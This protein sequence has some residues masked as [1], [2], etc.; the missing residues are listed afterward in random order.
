MK[1]QYD[2]GEFNV[3][4]KTDGLVSLVWHT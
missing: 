1:L 3:D 2:I 4:C